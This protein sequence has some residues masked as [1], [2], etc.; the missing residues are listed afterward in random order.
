ME[1]E[2][3]RVLVVELAT[4]E[5]LSN[6]TFLN[7]KRLIG[8]NVDPVDS[9]R[10]EQTVKVISARNVLEFEIDCRSYIDFLSL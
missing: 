5:R 7:E 9:I 6:Q 8:F 4:N 10:S 2:N 1:L 3:T